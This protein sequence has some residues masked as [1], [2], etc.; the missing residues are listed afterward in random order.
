MTLL[1]DG[2]LP[3]ARIKKLLKETKDEINP[4]KILARIRSGVDPEFFQTTY[5]TGAAD[6]FGPKEVIL[7]EY[8]MGGK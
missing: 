1:R 6:T 4:L 7:S 3:K 8:L 2:A 5:V